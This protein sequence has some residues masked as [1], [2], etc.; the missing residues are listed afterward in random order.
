MNETL[1][2]PTAD[3]NILLTESYIT[4]EK[5]NKE[6]GKKMVEKAVAILK[7]GDNSSFLGWGIFE[8]SMYY[9]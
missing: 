4:K 3:G 5:G 1:K 8:L 7:S 2:S 9:S 6:E